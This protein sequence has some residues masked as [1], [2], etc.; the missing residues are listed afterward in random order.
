MLILKDII[1]NY[2]EPVLG[3]IDIEIKSKS[4]VSIIGASGSGKSTFLRLASGL[5]SQSSGSISYKNNIKPKMGFVFQDSTLLP[6]RN[7]IDNVLLPLELTKQ[8]N[9]ESIEKSLNWLERVGLKGKEN[10]FPNELS[11]GQKMRVSIARALVQGGDF[12]LLDEPFS[13]LDEVT[14]RKLEDDLLE[15]WET[16]NITVLFVTHSVSQAVYLSQRVVV[17][18]SGPGII[19][20]DLAIEKNL[21]DGFEETSEFISQVRHLTN[22]LK[23]ERREI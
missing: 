12:L 2:E 3:P 17:L 4:F 9:S 21:K 23:K 20:E 11:G 7:V 15:I 13:A 14:R 16:N 18:S 10:S 22:I 19:L 5:I 1:K 6:W 8:N